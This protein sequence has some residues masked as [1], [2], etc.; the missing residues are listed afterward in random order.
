MV[1]AS[2]ARS[3]HRSHVGRRLAVLVAGVLA[4]AVSIVARDGPALAHG[5]VITVANATVRCTQVTGLAKFAPPIRT[6]GSDHG[7]ET[8][9]LSL[10]LEG[11]SSP[12]LPPPIS[13][14]GQLKGSLVANN[15][16]SCT[17]SFGSTSYA[18]V[19]TLVVRWK[20]HRAKISPFSDFAPQRVHPLMVHRARSGAIQTMKVGGSGS[21][22]PSVSGD[23]TGGDKGRASSFTVA[24]KQSA[25]TCSV[26]LSVLPIASG[27]LAFS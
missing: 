20:T 18:S 8:V 14:S 7:L 23:F 9:H 15:G 19:G 27:A 2:C 11:C 5:P 16:T 26:G 1:C 22:R 24:W 12:A 25:A 13:L 10:A 3:D 17:T 6:G 4:V 21:P